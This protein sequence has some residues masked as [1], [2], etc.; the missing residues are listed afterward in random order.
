MEKVVAKKNKKT[1]KVRGTLYY[2][3]T[4]ASSRQHTLQVKQH[5]LKGLFQT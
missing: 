1:N 5:E 2:F 4:A 3:D